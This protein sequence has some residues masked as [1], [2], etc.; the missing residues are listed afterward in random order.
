MVNE[1][2][3]I[4]PFDVDP[5]DAGE[6]ALTSTPLTA[7]EAH[8]LTTTIREAAEALWVLIARAHAGQAWLALGYDTW[9]AYVRGEFNMS[10]SRSYAILDQAKVIAAIEAAVPEGTVVRIS[11]AAAKDLKPVLDDLVANLTERT[12]HL[13]AEAASYAVS[14][15]VEERRVNN[16]PLDPREGWDSVSSGDEREYHPAEK[17]KATPTHGVLPPGPSSEVPN[18]DVAR[19]RRNVNAAHDLYSSLT[20]LS[21]LPEQ[22]DEVVA[23]IPVERHAQIK[24]NLD[25][26]V[27]NLNRF[28]NLWRT[29]E[30]PEDDPDF[31]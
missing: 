21:S 27:E 22:L 31:D 11:A 24:A 2:L 25:A 6:V 10:R 18:V 16:G 3:N 5:H 13:D 29:A 17:L 28:G 9:E 30:T 1:H 12:E 26:A 19:I 23:I 14:E 7:E 20:A 15:Y 8:N 4:E